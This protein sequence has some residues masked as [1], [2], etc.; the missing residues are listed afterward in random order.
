MLTERVL[1]LGTTF[2]NRNYMSGHIPASADILPQAEPGKSYLIYAHI[3]FCM[4]LCTFC[5]F[6][7]FYFKECRVRDYFKSL[8]REMEMTKELGYDFEAMYIGGG[9]PTVQL[10]ELVS[11]IDYAKELFPN[12]KNVS[13]ETNPVDLNDELY[14]ALG[15]RVQRMSVGVQSFDN[16]LLDEMR[17]SDTTGSAEETLAAV[18][19][20][21]GKF[22]SFNVDMIFNFPNQSFE[23]LKRDLQLVQETGCN[24]TTFYP[25]LASPTRRRQMAKQVGKVH[26]SREFE[27][28]KVVC[29]ELYGAGFIGSSVWTFSRD[30]DMMIDEYIVDYPEY[31]GIGS[32]AMSYL[33]G[34]NY[35]NTFSLR[36]YH[37]TIARG[38]MPI[39][40]MTTGSDKK[41]VEMRYYFASKLFGLRLDKNEFRER[42]GVSIERGMP[43]E[44]TFMRLTGAF[45]TNTKD[46]LTLTPK[47]RYLVLVMMRTTLAGENDYRDQMR[48]NLGKD[49][50][51]ELLDKE[52]NSM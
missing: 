51:K 47:G 29:E 5:S 36:D 24:Q 20:A 22:D 3:P 14:D 43:L 18:Q 12:I 15:K 26:Y 41:I 19:S 6:N 13:T 35:T 9:T 1:T 38:K 42:F 17:R 44:M 27:M 52:T 2:L 7:R 40:T 30:E 48:A 50:H 31:V 32:S 11:F 34:R 28:Y 23:V 37:D 8:K 45:A 10:D 39:A 21:Q 16:V 25:L 33:R 46:E 49:E 4:Q